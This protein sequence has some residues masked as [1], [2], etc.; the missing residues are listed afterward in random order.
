MYT[1]NGYF[2]AKI[3]DPQHPVFFS[4]KYPVLQYNILFFSSFSFGGLYSSAFPRQINLVLHSLKSNL[5]ID[6]LNKEKRV[7]IFVKLN[8]RISGTLLL[9]E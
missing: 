9:N 8:L 6:P 1:D 5:V 3:S 4:T 2:S 7:A